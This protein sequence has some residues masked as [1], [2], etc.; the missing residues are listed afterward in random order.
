MLSR[1]DWFNRVLGLWRLAHLEDSSALI[2][3]QFTETANLLAA[4]LIQASRF[5]PRYF[6]NVPEDHALPPKQA[7]RLSR[8]GLLLGRLEW[9]L[10]C[11]Q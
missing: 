9:G 8:I 5:I 6:T 3:D 4:H 1:G 11:G 7:L 10:G 2:P